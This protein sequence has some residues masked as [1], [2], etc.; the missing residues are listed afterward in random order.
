MPVWKPLRTIRVFV[1][2]SPP[3]VKFR[4][5]FVQ[6]EPS[7]VYGAG[8]FATARHWTM[9]VIVYFPHGRSKDGRSNDGACNV[10]EQTNAEVPDA[11]TLYIP[12]FVQEYSLSGKTLNEQ[13]AQLLQKD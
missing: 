4:P 6:F 11:F 2:F 5:Y 9:L 3:L 12:D 7:D 13:N 1:Y 10:Q 8:L